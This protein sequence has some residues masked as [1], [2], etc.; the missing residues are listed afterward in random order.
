ML[1]GL[2]RYVAM[3]YG[4]WR[5]GEGG[6]QC[7]PE[8]CAPERGLNLRDCVHKQHTEHRSIA[9]P[10]SFYVVGEILLGLIRLG[11]VFSYSLKL[12]ISPTQTKLV[13]P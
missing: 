11:R 8:P 4:D 12:P 6:A 1:L 2:R 10:R 7:G 5:H 3:L 9:P 13:F